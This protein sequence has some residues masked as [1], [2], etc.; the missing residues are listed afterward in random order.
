MNKNKIK[1]TNHIPLLKGGTRRK[2]FLLS[3][4]N[5]PAGVYTNTYTIT[6]IYLNTLIYSI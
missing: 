4:L 3:P 6:P 2:K 5:L 1:I